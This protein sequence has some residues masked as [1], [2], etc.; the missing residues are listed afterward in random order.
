MAD[1]KNEV[2][3]RPNQP[4]GI[5]QTGITQE[6]RTSYINY[7]MSV[8]VAR[9][10]PDVKDGLKPV[11]KRILYSMFKLKIL[12]TGSYKKSARTVGDV[13]GKYHPHGDVS[14]YDALARMAQDFSLRYMLIDG[15]GNF[16]SIDGDGA[17]AMRYTECRLHK[18]S[19]LM[20]SDI[21]KNTVN[22]VPTY[23]GSYREP[24]V[25]PAAIPN[26]LL[27][28]T[29]GIAVGMATKIPPHNLGE[30][31]DAIIDMIKKGNKWVSNGKQD[32]NKNYFENIKT[33]E[34]LKALSSDR[35]PS[36]ESEVTVDRL[37][38]FIP[39]PDFPTGAAIYDAKEIANA[40]A[41]G[42]GRILMRA[43]AGIT[44]GKGGKFHIIISEI[45]YQVNKARLV[46]KIAD[47]VKN[48]KIEGISDIRDESNKEGLRVV[49]DIKRDGKPKT[50][51]NKLYKLTEMQKAF[52]ANMLAIVEGEP[53]ILTLKRILE[54]FIQHRQEIVIRRSEFDLAKAR[55]QEHILEG[56]MIALANL[57]D[58]IETIKKSKDAETAKTNLIK[59]FKLSDIQAQAILDMQLRRLAALERQKIEEEYKK[60][61]QTIKELLFILRT[62]EKVLDIISSE[63]T[64][65]KK[66][67]SDERRT[68]VYKGKVDEF[69]EED[70]VAAEEVLVTVSEQG[71]IKRMKQGTY[72]VQKRGGKG[73]KGMTTKEED[74]VA[75]VFSCNT[76][77]DILFFTTKGR[78]FQHKV[79]DIPEFG[80]TAKGQ[81]IINLI[82]IDQDELITS[83]LTRSKEGII[84]EDMI[85][86]DQIGLEKKGKDFKYLFMATRHGTVKKTE[87]KEF[88]KIRANGLISIKLADKDEL[89]WVKPTTGE[90]EV[91]LITKYGRSIH[92]SEKD[93]RETGR[94]TMGVRGIKFKFADDEVISMDIIRKKED[95]MLTISEKGYGKVT[96]M[97]QY[98]LQ[99]RGGQGVFTARLSVKTGK[100]AVARVIDHPGAELLIMAKSGQA[101]KIPTNELPERNR[102]TAGV[103]LMQ[104]KPTDQVAA[105]AII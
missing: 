7:A 63:L 2:T 82:N 41:T 34:D 58:V 90:N 16:G 5:I 9:A 20:L 103:R 3:V 55:E 98:P 17:A 21:E 53:R 83:I 94:A 46:E 45:P 23:D 91:I 35:F 26:L 36:F 104:I 71:Y 87:I 93:V 28:G 76:H 99:G 49:I 65:V 75:H 60:I 25:L 56:L 59:K 51:L 66:K 62:P 79:Y 31:S 77:D 95:L 92:F 39:G 18:I 22:Y 68:K 84:E 8:I 67:F 73:K 6:M 42:R 32:D 86:E 13:I 30:V 4:K 15:Q 69:T 10:L 44:E 105:I 100:L 64:E 96:R 43:R 78:V 54:L 47:L 33:T 27:N 80:R 38:E 89:N 24:L 97:G 1:D 101:V 72:R 74:S 52:N 61:K 88:D 12:P 40:Y 81:A 14:V 102:Q 57:D 50:I 11:Q 85:Q 70:L 37:M 29:E 48:K 19:M